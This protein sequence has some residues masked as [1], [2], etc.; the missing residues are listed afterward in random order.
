MNRKNAIIALGVV[1]IMV[2]FGAS[3]CILSSVQADS[4]SSD[5]QRIVVLSAN[6]STEVGMF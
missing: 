1:L 4:V 5:G 2:G 6:S 3:N